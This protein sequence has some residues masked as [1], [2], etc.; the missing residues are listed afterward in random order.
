VSSSSTHISRPF[1]SALT[2]LTT[3]TSSISKRAA[4]LAAALLAA[5]AVASAAECTVKYTEGQ[6]DTPAI[7][8]A[9]DECRENS[10]ITFEAGRNYSA[11]TPVT[12]DNLST[13]E[14]SQARD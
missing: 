12:L 10:I 6:D 9:L 1:K 14:L 3:M 2:H 5:V 7:L 11:Y 4:A 8:S 13:F